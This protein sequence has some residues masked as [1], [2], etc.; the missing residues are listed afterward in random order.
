MAQIIFS[1]I[2]K[3]Y[4]NYQD[5]KPW[6]Q[7]NSYP[8]FCGYSWVI[9]QVSL[10]IDHYKPQEYFLDLKAK[11][12]NLILCSHNCNSAKGDYHPEAKRRRFYKG[13]T[14][15]IF[16]YREED[17]G[18]IVKL[19][20]DGS[21]IFRSRFQRDR[22]YFNEQVFKFNQDH[23][24]EIRKEYLSILKTLIEIDRRFKNANGNDEALIDMQ[25]DLERAKELCSR[26]YIFYKL[27]N[28]KIPKHIEKLLTNKTTV[29]FLSN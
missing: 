22:F 5:Y 23:F 3:Q 13:Y 1:R 6:L 2:A 16:N 20:E 26:R 9:D 29:Q 10:A 11:P 12:D 21:L 17:I 4:N 18:K 28:I 19:R 7:E 14:H 25:R 24:Q 8:N 15:K 27:L